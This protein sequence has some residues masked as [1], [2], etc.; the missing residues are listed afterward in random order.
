MEL[1]CV[2]CKKKVNINKYENKKSKN[3]RNYIMGRCPN[4]ESKMIRFVKK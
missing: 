2:K 1:Y 3:G 4:C